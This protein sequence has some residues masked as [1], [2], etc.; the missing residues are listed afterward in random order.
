[1]ANRLCTDLIIGSTSSLREAFTSTSEG[2]ATYR[3]Q[4]SLSL[5]ARISHVAFTAD[6]SHLVLGSASGGLAVY[7]VSDLNNSSNASALFQL[8]TNGGLREVKPNP[9][10][11]EFVAI[12]T[13]KGDVQM[14]NLNTRAWEQGANGPVLKSNAST[15]SWSQRGKQIVCGMGDGT[16]WQMTPQGEGRAVLPSVPGLDNHFV[17]SIVWL[18][19]HFF[20]T[21]HTPVP[22]EEQNN[23][24]VFHILTRSSKGAS[25]QYTRLPDP[26]PPF[27]MDA[28]SPPY[29][30]HARIGPYAP[31]MRDMVIFS[32]TCSSDIGLVSRFSAPISGEP[33]IPADTWCTTTIGDDTRRAQLPLSGESIQDTSSIGMALDFSNKDNVKRPVGGEE[34]EESPGPLPILMVLNHEGLLCAWHVVYN[35]AIESREKYTGMMIYAQQTQPQAQQQQQQQPPRPSTPPQPTSFAGVLGSPPSQQTPPTGGLGFGF[36]GG[37]RPG[38]SEGPFASPSAAGL[39]SPRLST[40]GVYGTTSNLGGSF[41]KPSFGTPF[42]QPSALGASAGGTFGQ[43][44]WG[45][46]SSGPATAAITQPAGSAFSQTSALG[47]KPA[48]AAFGQTPALGANSTG[49]AFGQTSA[50]GARP[51]FGTPTALGTSAPAFG[52]PTALGL[53]KPAAS[54]FGQLSAL[55]GTTAA[56]SVFGSGSALGG[57]GSGGFGSYANKGG[58]SAVAGTG[59]STSGTPIW[60]SG[61]TINTES[62]P[63]AFGT[64]SAP[65]AFGAGGATGFKISSGFKAEGATSDDST[66]TAAGGSFGAFGAG[67]GD[68]LSASQSA[69][70]GVN[71]QA[72]RDADMDADSDVEQDK[73]S[74]D[75][76]EDIITPG[77]RQLAAPLKPATLPSSSG[78][79]FAAVNKP[80]SSPFGTPS[81]VP[82]SS[83]FGQLGKG[84]MSTSTQQS[85]FSNWKQTPTSFSKQASPFGT[86]TAQARDNPFS[87]TPAKAANNPFSSTPPAVANNPFGTPTGGVPAS[88]SPFSLPAKQVASAFG[89]A[90]GIPNKPSPSPAASKEP[91]PDAAPLPPDFTKVK[92]KPADEVPDTPLPPDFT[93][94]KP[95]KVEVPDAPLPPDFTATPKKEVDRDVS[96]ENAPLPPDFTTPA[97]SKKPEEEDIPSLPADGSEDEDEADDEEGYDEGPYDQEEEG[98]EE[99]GEGEEEQREEEDEDEEEGEE[100]EEDEDADQNP[101]LKG[102]NIT[103]PKGGLFSYDLKPKTPQSA[104][105]GSSV[106][107]SAASYQGAIGDSGIKKDAPFASLFEAKPGVSADKDHG[108]PAGK[109]SGSL[110][111]RVSD[112]KKGSPGAHGHTPPGRDKGGKSGSGMGGMFSK[113]TKKNAQTIGRTPPSAPAQ[114]PSGSFFPSPTPIPAPAASSSSSVFSPNN[115]SAAPSS[116]FGGG[117]LSTKQPITSPSSTSSVFA[118]TNKAQAAPFGGA[119]FVSG[120]TKP[121][122]SSPLASGQPQSPQQ[123]SP[124]QQSPRQQSPQQ[125]S[126]RQQLLQSPLQLPQQLPREKV[127]QRIEEPKEESDLD[128]EKEF[129]D[130]EDEKIRRKLVKGKVKPLENLPKFKSIGEVEVANVSFHQ[131]YMISFF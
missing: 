77:A 3:P 16:L 119:N 17:S 5:P 102:V 23:E 36:G 94:A 128:L 95:G 104:S 66:K 111:D 4:L 55:G 115:K 8:G 69:L 48:A 122:R 70:R 103:P 91:S 123:Q 63:S 100:E 89:P 60:G 65:S 39:T 15:V 34:I 24:S 130:R 131:I 51:A 1:M 73:A 72:L 54:A 112:P 117:N 52:S 58:F 43:P 97:K 38:T 57:A 37:P 101:L 59:A 99:G 45:A 7:S 30:F 6:E 21:T 9:E 62:T 80:A 18:E 92:P 114:T 20:I 113:A 50:L 116:L 81:A 127:E 124:H 87:S 22:S 88:A 44:A 11:P 109:P 108:K 56:G 41:G 118:T 85:A 64:G 78:S 71:N 98:E 19:N 47:A 68:A 14:L 42:G 67:L 90:G 53:A 86:P 74:E 105:P 2:V 96:A 32:N 110:F 25:F 31:N 125:Q 27:G 84:P 120:A 129:S 26:V 106:F 83:P 13:T 75:E 35:D 76:D 40:G 33:P 61:K 82:P 79:P 121:A 28:R 49:S 46:A 12:V 107:G 29:F 126:P 93:T 10:T